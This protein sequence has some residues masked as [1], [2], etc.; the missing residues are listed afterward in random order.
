MRKSLLA[1]TAL[2]AAGAFAVG[3]ASASDR[4]SVGVGGYMEQWIGA[5]DVDNGTDDNGGISQWS[6]SEI[7]FRGSLEA[8]NGLTF[9]VKVELEGNTSSDQIDESQATVSGSFGQIVLGS[10]D[11]PASL[12][13]Y[14]NQDVGVGLNCG[15]P[16]WVAGVTSCAR[17]G[18]KGLGTSGWI[19]G[20]D[21]QKI[22]Y[23]TP[24]MAGMQFGAAYIPNASGDTGVSEDI[25][26]APTNNDEDAWS[27]GLNY[28]GDMGD[29][30]VGVSFGHYQRNQAGGML[31]AAAEQ[32]ALDGGVGNLDPIRDNI[33]ARDSKGDAETFTNFG[34]QIGF[35]AFGFDV[36]Y[37]THD[38]GEYMAVADPSKSILDA[39]AVS[40]VKNASKDYDVTSAG[41]M[42][43]D[44]P[45][46]ASLS[47]MM[48]DADDGGEA[49]TTMLSFRYGLAPGIASRTSLMFGEQDDVDGTAFVTGIRIDF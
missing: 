2:A 35:G 49:S 27:V 18:G 42:Y 4:M 6:D 7:Y 45:M 31:V 13:H 29:A 10:E 11:H 26:I 20:G 24:R 19:V 3:T 23:Y 47:H 46:S 44:G 22:A 15:D 12:M 43:S 39:D 38:G 48:A 25:N 9:S 16:S 1:T 28:R 40:V 36:A 21:D 14:G 41:M 32:A 30:S 34:L 33:A 37:A 17:E 5:A 8:D